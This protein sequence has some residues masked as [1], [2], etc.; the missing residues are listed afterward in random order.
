MV[1]NVDNYENGGSEH[2]SPN[3]GGDVITMV[4]GL[5]PNV[6]KYDQIRSPNYTIW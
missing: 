1:T 4:S 5:D 3:L 2:N 6:L